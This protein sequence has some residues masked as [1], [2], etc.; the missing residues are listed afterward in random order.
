MKNKISNQFFISY[1]IV[2]VMS[3][4]AT[5][6][7]IQAMSFADSVI[8]KTLVKNN[9]TADSIMQ[10]DYT[11]IDT[12][13]VVENNG[14]VQVVNKNYKVIYS[15]GLNILGDETLTKEEFTDFLINSNSV[16][17]PYNI[18]IQYNQAGDF[19]LIVTFPTSLR[20]DLAFVY[21]K[22][23]ASKDMQSVIGLI[24]AVVLFYF[25]MLA[26]CAA[27]YSKLTA[28][29]FT[30]PLQKLVEGTKDLRSGDYSARVK[31]DLKNE[32]YELQET[33]NA[34]AEQIG[35]EISLRQQ[36]DDNRKKLILDISHDLKN[37]LAAILGYS[38][39][40]QKESLIY[41]EEFKIRL[42]IIYENSIRANKLLTNLF[43]LSKLESAE[44]SLNTACEDICEYIRETM[45]NYVSALEDADFAYNFDIPEQEIFVSIDKEQMNRVFANLMENAL[46][47]NDA[48]TEIS[49]CIWREK[50]NAV[51]LFADNGIGIP[52]DMDKA[53]FSPFMRGDASRNSRTGGTGLGLSIAKMI[54]QKHGGDISLN[55]Q[56]NTGCVFE[57]RIPMI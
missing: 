14:G 51:I 41:D 22:A 42:K 11:T 17:V 27:V 6:I 15:D 33:F 9:Y 47:Y 32:F 16:G 19:W 31:L 2:F 54:V 23:I 50:F 1:I 44:F 10:D 8:A 38:E 56:Q 25:I 35:Y 53:I 3:I 18:D 24:V 13:V 55:R 28:I 37:P 43:E 29:R 20:I 7:A 12:T 30:N 36:S 57:V 26:I 5:A 4:V 46:K 52:S 21:N 48:G 40:C 45:S 39:L 49:V 34:M